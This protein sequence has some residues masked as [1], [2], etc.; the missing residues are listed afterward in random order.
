MAMSEITKKGLIS[1]TLALC[2]LL[3]FALP[4]FAGLSVTNPK[5]EAT[6]ALGTET[7]YKMIVAD[8]SD[9]PMDV[10]IEVKGYG[11]API[12]IKVLDPEEDISPYTARHFLSVSPNKFHLEPG[13]SQD[14]IVT[15]RIPAGIDDGGRYAIIYIHTIPPEGSSF[16]TVA[17]VAA[18]VLLT[19]DGSE[20]IQSGEINEIQLSKSESGQPREI[21]AIVQNTGNYHYK[22][23]AI[24]EIK[25]EQGEV[26][27]TS[28]PLANQFPLLP[29]YS[30]QISI[31]IEAEDDLP[32]GEYQADIEVRTEDGTLIAQ[33]TNAFL[34][35]EPGEPP[36][37]QE[38]PS[39]NGFNW[40]LIGAICAGIVIL[41]I[42]IHIARMRRRYI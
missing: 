33:R 9:T 20:L 42:V 12:G 41:V 38:L 28:L 7:T 22:I 24:C 34:L 29:T 17:A 1:L 23:T 19:I 16:A 27:A 4:V 21:M 25:N 5:I 37:Q 10:A 14:V 11:D 3:V 31:P 32:M 8:T 15:A 2:L 18:R 26:V 35:G 6:V 13:E 30:R 39:E 36:P 40:T